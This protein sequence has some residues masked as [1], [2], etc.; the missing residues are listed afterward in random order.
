MHFADVMRNDY[1]LS[2]A[3]I[4]WVPQPNAARAVHVETCRHAARPHSTAE[5]PVGQMAVLRRL[6]VFC[7]NMV[8]LF[9]FLFQIQLSP[10]DSIMVTV[11][12][13]NNYDTMIAFETRLTM[14][15]VS[16]C[17]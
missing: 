10:P 1:N 14:Y 3:Q 4:S 13:Q 5:L 15:V 16:N 7:I 8:S 17:K 11:T 9:T 12:N 2:S 6:V